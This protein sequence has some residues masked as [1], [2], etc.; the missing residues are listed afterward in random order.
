VIW[1]ASGD[2]F[3]LNEIAAAVLPT[4]WLLE[5]AFGI[6]ADGLSIV[7][8]GNNADGNN[9]AWLLHLDFVPV[10]EPG[11]GL[12]MALGLLALAAARRR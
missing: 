2:I 6:S 11:T 12:L 4:G 7:G 8:R 10:P 9:E 1:N 3:D 5:E